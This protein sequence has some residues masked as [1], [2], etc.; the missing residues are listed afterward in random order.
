MPAIELD[1]LRQCLV[2]DD[3]QRATVSQLLAHEYFDAEFL[4]DFAQRFKTDL[5]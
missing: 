1:F 2:I 5:D 4:A 3:T